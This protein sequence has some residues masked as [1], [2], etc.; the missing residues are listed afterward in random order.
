MNGSPVS[1]DRRDPDGRGSPGAEDSHGSRASGSRLFLSDPPPTHRRARLLPC[2]QGGGEGEGRTSD[3]LVGGRQVVHGPL[4]GLL[5][6][7]PS[8]GAQFE[9]PGN[10][11]VGRWAGLPQLRYG[12][13]SLDAEASH[14]LRASGSRLFRSDPPLMRRRGHIA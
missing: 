14:G 11:D 9:R 10:P 2:R 1:P 4:A 5:P 7:S 6:H 13:G 8:P 12:R 3:P